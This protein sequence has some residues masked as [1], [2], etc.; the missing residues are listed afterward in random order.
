MTLEV[1]SKVYANKDSEGKEQWLSPLTPVL[2]SK[3]KKWNKVYTHFLNLKANLQLE[4]LVTIH[5]RG[6]CLPYYAYIHSNSYYGYDQNE[7]ISRYTHRYI[8]KE[9]SLKI[10]VSSRSVVNTS[11]NCI[12]QHTPAFEG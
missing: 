10:E 5:R 2:T 11:Q 9:I 12:T 1:K 6:L 7:M 3:E 4:C 8:G